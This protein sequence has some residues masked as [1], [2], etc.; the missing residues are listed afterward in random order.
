MLMLQL[1]DVTIRKRGTTVFAVVLTMASLSS[2]TVAQNANRATQRSNRITQQM[3]AA[4][5]VAVTGSVHPLTRRA[6][7]LG[8]VNS[9]MPLNSLTLNI[10]LSTSQQKW[11]RCWRRSRIHRLLS[12]ANG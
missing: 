2:Q 1:L 8:A 6:T 7:D 3:D 11:M 9:L 12:I 4:E 5:M 10:G